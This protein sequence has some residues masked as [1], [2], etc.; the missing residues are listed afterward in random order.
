VELVRKRTEWVGPRAVRQNCDVVESRRRLRE[1]RERINTVLDVIS[2]G[3][4]SV[5]Y[6]TASN[7]DLS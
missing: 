2:L 1:S 6:T 3:V 7:V 5:D 4:K